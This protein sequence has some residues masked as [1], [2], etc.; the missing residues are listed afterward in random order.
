MEIISF[1]A[2]WFIAEKRKKN[3]EG[4][5]GEKCPKCQF[6]YFS[7]LYLKH[8]VIFNNVVIFCLFDPN[9]AISNEVAIPQ[10]AF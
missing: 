6:C 1:I 7:N 3:K 5:L 2:S 4:R 9:K 10:M 8:P